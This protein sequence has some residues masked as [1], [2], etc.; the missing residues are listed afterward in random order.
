MV[1]PSRLSYVSQLVPRI[2][3]STLSVLR[4]YDNQPME[5]AHFINKEARLRE[6]LPKDVQLGNDRR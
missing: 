3:A 5:G 1:K 4:R 2:Q 6:S